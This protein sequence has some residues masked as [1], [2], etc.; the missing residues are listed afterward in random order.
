METS[1]DI[2]EK[3][4]LKSKQKCSY[5]LMAEIPDCQSPLF[6]G[7]P[8]GNLADKSSRIQS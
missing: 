6:I 4:T 1:E 5:D 2:K 8:L 7:L 3:E